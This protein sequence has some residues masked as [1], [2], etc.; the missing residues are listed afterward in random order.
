[1]DATDATLLSETKLLL[2]G[3]KNQVGKSSVSLFS[4]FKKIILMKNN[5]SNKKYN[6]CTL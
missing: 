1:M 5:V 6:R 2:V 4:A 3:T